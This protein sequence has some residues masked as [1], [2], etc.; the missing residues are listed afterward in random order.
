MPVLI[1]I[2]IDSG[3]DDFCAVF[4]RG[5]IRFYELILEPLRNSGNQKTD[6]NQ[7]DG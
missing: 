3:D 1:V 5:Y 6:D 7:S 4:C 2:G